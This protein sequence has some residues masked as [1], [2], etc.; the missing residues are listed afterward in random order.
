V[1]R[2]NYAFRAVRLPPGQHEV[3]FTFAPR[4]W[5]MGLIISGLVGLALVA[6][7]LLRITAG[8]RFWISPT[9][10]EAG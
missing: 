9:K 1:L 8:R 3:E 10:R 4:S 6:R 7:A 2:A 5:R